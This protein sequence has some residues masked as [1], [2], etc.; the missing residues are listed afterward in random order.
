MNAYTRGYVITTRIINTA[1]VVKSKPKQL[2]HSITQFLSG[3]IQ[4]VKNSKTQPKLLEDIS[5]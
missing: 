4:A 3:S 5:S 2:G 1:S